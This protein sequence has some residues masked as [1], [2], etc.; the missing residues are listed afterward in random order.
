[1]KTVTVRASRTY[2][3]CIG[4]GLLDEAGERIRRAAPCER[5]MLVSDDTVNA[6]WG[7]RAEKSLTD[8][9]LRVDRFIF[10]HGEQSKTLDTYARLLGAL[11]ALEFTSSDVIAAL[12]GGVTGDLAGFAA[13]T[14][15]RGVRCIQLPT[16]LLAAVDSSV[17]GKTAVDLPGGKNLCGAFH[18]PSLVLC[19]TKTL[20]TLPEEF[21]SDGCAEV[22]K[23]GV[24]ADANLFE[25]LNVPF[26]DGPEDVIARC[27]EIKRDVVARD[28]FDRGDRALLNFGHTFGHAV[29]HCSGYALSHGRAVAVGMAMITRAAVRRGLCSPDVENRLLA[30][31]EQVGLPVRTEIES[32]S[33]LRAMLEDKKR[34]GDTIRLIVPREIGRAE[35]VSVKV[36]ELP[37]WLEDGR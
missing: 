10:P 35:I 30:L 5:V 20:D 22:I 26:R 4:P 37:A 1:M 7:D 14:Y 9:G 25:R 23:Y 28:E 15:R 12:G 16:T 2:D 33:L 31:L 29:E 24:I 13:A 32:I 3:V 34:R 18:Q 17:G 19:D 11:C 6:L 27:V 8:A 36:A 21:F